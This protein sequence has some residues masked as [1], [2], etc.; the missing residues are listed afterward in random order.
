MG[1]TGQGWSQK[2]WRAPWVVLGSGQHP[3]TRAICPA[4]GISLLIPPDAIPRGK[5]YEV[6]LALH[7]QED[8]R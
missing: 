7:K 2:D 8:A 4:A 5:I 3:L 6:Y 1:G